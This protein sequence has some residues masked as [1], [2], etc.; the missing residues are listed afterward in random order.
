MAKSFEETAAAQGWSLTT[1]L[2]VLLDFIN[3]ELGATKDL[4]RYAERRA[5]DESAEP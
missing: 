5:A 2:V 1:Q 3:E 4:N